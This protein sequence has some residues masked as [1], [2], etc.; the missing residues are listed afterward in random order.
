M[1]LANA[2]SA[3]AAEKIAQKKGKGKRPNAEE[4]G[5]SPAARK[6]ELPP[7]FLKKKK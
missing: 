3:V 4:V 7:A 1:S 5:E 2:M 6:A